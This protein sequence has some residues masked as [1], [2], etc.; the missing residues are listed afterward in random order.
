MSLKEQVHHAVIHSII[1][2][3]YPPRS[4]LNEKDLIEKYQV[5]KS[6]VRDALLE[7][8]SEG[9]LR[10]IPRVG[11]EVVS[12]SERDMREISQFRF[13][14]ES[15]CLRITAKTI[16]PQQLEQLEDF[17]ADAFEWLKTQRDITKHWQ[18]NMDF[19]LL[20]NSFAK[21][22]YIYLALKRSMNTQLRGYAQFY[23][24]KWKQTS[25]MLDMTSHEKIVQAIRN[26]DAD[27]AV[28]CLAE[29]LGRLS[30]CL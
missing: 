8:C 13:I 18:K 29:D 27:S 1:S 26:K 10:S 14:L 5:S 4:I 11:Y 17:L 25:V 20:L 16:S 30:D 3:D 6:P 19:H 2:G 7:L 24:D 21:N 28:N 23:W 15:Q 22:Q 9:A 12:L